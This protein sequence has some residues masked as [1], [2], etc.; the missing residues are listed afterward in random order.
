MDAITPQDVAIEIGEV[1]AEASAWDDFETIMAEIGPIPE[2]PHYT[3]PSPPIPEF[4]RFGQLD[5]IV[6]L[7]PPPEM[8]RYRCPSPPVPEYPYPRPCQWTKQ[9]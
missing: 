2:I 1:P 9:D 8:P 3:C 5:P 6:R 4:G 7:G